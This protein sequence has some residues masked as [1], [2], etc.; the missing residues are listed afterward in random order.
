[1]Y[2]DRCPPTPPA[3]LR[4]LAQRLAPWLLA[5]AA[6][7]AAA[8]ARAAI[9]LPAWRRD[10]AAARVLAEN[11][12]PRAMAEARRLEAALPPDAP[13]TDRARVLN[14]LARIET[15]QGLSIESEVHSKQAFE[16]ASASGDKIGQA[17]SDLNVALNSINL[18]KLEE[19]VKSTNRAVATLENVDRPDLLSEALLRATVMY[20][21]FEQ[22]EESV[23]VAV[24]AMEI[25]RRSGNP[26]A[27]AYAH[28]GLAISYDQSFR[29]A[30]SQQ[31]Y[32][33]MLVQARAAKSRM[34]EGFSVSG[35]AAQALRKK[36][37]LVGERLSRDSLVIFREIGAPFAE[38]FAH[39]GLAE[40]L[41]AQSR[42]GEAMAE[43]EKAHA[44]YD[45]RPNR[46]GLWFVLNTRSAIQQAL[47]NFAAAQADAEQGYDIAKS[48][49][50]AIYT[51]AGALRLSEVAAARGDYKQAYAWSNQA[52]ELSGQAARE[53]ASRRMVELTQ[54]YESESRQRQID[55]LTHR[56][57]QQT[58]ELRQR[59]LQ[60]RWLWTLLVGSVVVTTTIVYFLLRLRRSHQLLRS[61]NAELARS[62]DAVR[63][64]NAGLELRIEA[65]TAQLRQQA[66][67]LRTLIDML[68]LWAWFKDTDNRYLVTNQA[69]ARARGHRADEMI[70]KTDRE[71]LP[72]P[73]AEA[74]LAEDA[75]VMASRERRI[76]EIAVPDNG[77]ETWMES[78]KAPVLD[79][80]GTLL[81]TVGVARDISAQKATEAAREAAL[82]EAHRLAGTRSAFLAQM[83]HELRTP[84][85]AILGFAQILQSHAP[86]DERQARSVAIIQQSGQHLLAL[87]NDVL[88]LARVDAGK[89][90]LA[91]HDMPLA[92]FL[93]VVTDII[94]VKADEKGL[95]FSVSAPPDLP[96][97][98]RADE[99][100]LRQVLLNLLANA[101]KFS[102]A[103]LVT[104][105]LRRLPVEGATGE[106]PLLRLRFE[107]SDSGVGMSAEQL[108]RLFQPFEQVGDARRRSG[109]TGLG[110]AISHQLVRLMGSELRVRSQPG[111]GSVFWFDLDLPIS[112]EPADGGADAGPLLGYEGR[113]RRVLVVDDAAPLL[114]LMSDSLG[115]A[116][117]EVACAAN[118]QEALD[119]AV[120]FQPDLVVM[121]MTMPVLG[122][123]DALRRL[124]AMPAFADLPVIMSTASERGGAEAAC[125]AAGASMFLPKPV[126]PPVLLRAIGRLLGLSWI[127][128]GAEQQ[129]SAPLDGDGAVVSLPEDEMQALLRLARFGNMR[130]IRARAEHLQSLDPRYT[131]FAERLRRLADGYQSQAILALVESCQPA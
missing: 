97:A 51:S 32:Q 80:D 19:L 31:H 24:Q 68:P 69:H 52:R 59:E 57:E 54:R 39:Y 27:L 123:L 29:Q 130:E 2:D 35:M 120:S 42:L 111:Q 100:R 58:A 41:R 126:D 40:A 73:Q 107:V 28:Q 85:N 89:L 37:Y 128:A 7:L 64:L 5:L 10:A 121:D 106:P 45:R 75:Q 87:I 109:G 21:R 66:R 62:R 112:A 124:R 13:A 96:A 99:M 56:N 115:V 110:L 14:L 114:A 63:E 49:G 122:G 127:H 118:G 61:V 11:D 82:E 105:R 116:G 93:A 53:R 30:E 129:T 34:M 38:A 36:D 113:R 44:I 9:D 60:Q 25:A 67:Y 81:G 103:G 70:G 4:R 119:R 22:F 76:T 50:F 117:F 20:R 74:S 8:P 46:I 6:A 104:L 65:R 91:P 92:P 16:I 47:K 48:L 95:T 71:L 88:D 72:A 43:L 33:D 102:D 125:M 26:L 98:V 108:A 23:A 84:L 55:E 90:E 77:R 17:E 86:L 18:G 12:L 78:F 83:S 79:D 131:A 1:M 3:L 15:Y 101:V 94:R